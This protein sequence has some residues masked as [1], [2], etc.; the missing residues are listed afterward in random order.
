MI[1]VY[2]LFV[3][4]FLLPAAVAAVYH[5][6]LLAARI[7]GARAVA[8]PS[9]EASHTFAIVIPAHNEEQHIAKSVL[10]SC[11]TALAAD[12]PADKYAGVRQGV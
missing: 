8:P 11:G 12:Y 5:V 10:R 1:V 4:C 3:A 2:V 7:C 9:K 6:M